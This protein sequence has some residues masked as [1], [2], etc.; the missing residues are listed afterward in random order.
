MAD[1]E[2]AF[3]IGAYGLFLETSDGGTTWTRRPFFSVPL[4]LPEG[5]EP[6]EDDEGDYVDPDYGE[7]FHLNHIT[8][9]ADGTLYIAA[10]AGH[11][12]RSQDAGATWTALE[13]PYSGSFFGTL[14]LDGDALLLFGMRGNVFRSDDAGLSYT[15]IET[16]VQSLLT[17][18]FRA[19]DGRIVVTGLAGVVLESADGGKTFALHRQADR[20][21]NMMALPTTDA[22]VVLIGEGGVTMLSAND[23]R[24]GGVQ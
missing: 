12:Y 22:G 2:H 7:D 3:A 14:P 9:A 1:A 21:G 23:Y 20:R 19:K 10:E 13:P 4:P 17:S 6:A 16:N 8:N 15:P 11:Y 24:A 18:A 5:E